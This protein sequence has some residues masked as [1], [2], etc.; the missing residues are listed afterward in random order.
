[1]NTLNDVVKK[2][3]DA[4]NNKSIAGVF[5]FYED[6]ALLVMEPGRVAKGKEEIRDFFQFIFGLDVKAKQIAT[7]ILEVEDIALFTSR[8]AAEG[9]LPDGNSFT[10]ENVATSVFRKSQDGRWRLLI[11][12]SFGPEV[13]NEEDT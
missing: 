13:L 8:W 4:V 9:T 11:N 5:D 3:D 6:D 1:M 12:N 2:L 10:N 7:N